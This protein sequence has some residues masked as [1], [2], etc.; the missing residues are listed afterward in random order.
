MVTENTS[1]MMVQCTKECGSKT[2]LTVEEFISGL[3]AENTMVNGKITICMVKVSTH[4]RMVECIKV[5]MRMIASTD[6]VHTLGMMVNNMLDGGKMESNMVKEPT[7]RMDVIEKVSGKMERELDGSMI[8]SSMTFNNQDSHNKLITWVAQPMA[9]IEN[10]LR[11]YANFKKCMF[12]IIL[13]KQI[14]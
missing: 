3:M 14:N 9:T 6:M 5:N 11:N 4:G 2:K 13:L 7:A 1:G 10:Y 8:Q 12:S